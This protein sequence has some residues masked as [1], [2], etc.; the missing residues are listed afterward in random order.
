M[1][2][3]RTP[4]FL[5]LVSVLGGCAQLTGSDEGTF[6][7]EVHAAEISRLET[8]V[9]RLSEQLEKANQEISSLQA[10]NAELTRR[11]EMLKVL[12]QTVEEKRKTL[13]TQ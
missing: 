9:A 5:I 13:T 8:R 1:S 4:L 7:P 6:S 2:S 3:I 12:D 11:I 10:E